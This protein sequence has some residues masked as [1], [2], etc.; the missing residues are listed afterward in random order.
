MEIATRFIPAKPPKKFWSPWS[1]ENDQGFRWDEVGKS[2]GLGRRMG[3]GCEMALKFERS[4][5]GKRPL[6]INVNQY[7]FIDSRCPPPEFPLHFLLARLHAPPE[8][9]FWPTTSQPHSTRRPTP[10]HCITQVVD[11]SHPSPWTS[12]CSHPLILTVSASPLFVV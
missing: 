3:Q 7:F 10:A 9:A 8:S 6:S 5:V 11:P 12:P 1:L 4:D 2:T